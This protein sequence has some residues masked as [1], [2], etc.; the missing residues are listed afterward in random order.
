M[1]NN[2][3]FASS[4]LQLLAKLAKQQLARMKYIDYLEYIYPD[5]KR[6]HYNE[7]IALKMDELIRVG[8]KRYMFFLPPRHGKTMTI[9][10]SLPA[11]YLM[12][13]PNKQVMLV[14]YGADLSIDFGKGNRD[15]YRQYAPELFGQYLNE[16]KKSV[17]NWEV[18]NTRGVCFSTSIHGA[19]AGKGADLLII[20]D[21]I[22]DMTDL[23]TPE[24][25]D[26][27]YQQYLGAFNS[28]VH[29]PNASI[30][31]VQTRWHEGDLAGMILEESRK[32]KE[33]GENVEDWEIISFPALAEENDILGRKIGE[34]LWP[35]QY[36]YDSLMNIKNMVGNKL[37]S[38]LYQ[39]N[40]IIEDG[41]IFKY[42]DFQRY[43]NLPDKFD[44]VLQSWDTSFKNTIHSD[45]VVGQVWGKVGAKFYLI[46]QIRGRFTFNETKKFIV[47]MK[48]LFP[49]IRASLIEES[50]NG[51]AIINE[52]Q[53][54]ITG[55]I[56]IKARDSK[57][58]RARAI[59]PYVE[60]HNV[61]LPSDSIGDSVLNECTKFP[62]GAHDDQVDSLTQALNYFRDHDVR[63]QTFN[64]SILG[65]R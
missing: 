15:L 23:T 27:I 8:G 18:K 11:Y 31:I 38:S 26:A 41:D 13:N 19:A 44:T 46:H 56:P 30:V 49:D 1:N 53:D 47:K 42:A 57:E 51:H 40:P 52:L 34:P 62:N 61:F 10:K 59:T 21:P 28:R 32:L 9:T 63:I 20:D 50:S 29:R 36:N 24:K 14:S 6:T 39:Q 60:A 55:I 65:L 2:E 5:Y 33:L 48:E 3:E 37:W 12:H 25:R 64:K 35:K 17:V 43:T 4:E 16:N 22:K 54:K 7:Y 58:A 45:F